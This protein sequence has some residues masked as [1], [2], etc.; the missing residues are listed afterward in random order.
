MYSYI[1]DP[2]ICKKNKISHVQYMLPTFSL[3]QFIALHIF[4]LFVIVKAHFSK[5]G[6][7]TY[8]I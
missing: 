7:T 8:F 6:N 1:F 2:A 4:F 5:I 3:L